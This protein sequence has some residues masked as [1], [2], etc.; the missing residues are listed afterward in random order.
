MIRRLHTGIAALVAITVLA[1]L[2][3]VSVGFD[4]ACGNVE[5]AKA[6]KNV[7]PGGHAPLAIGDSTMLLALPAL[8]REGY[9]V[10]AHG[11]RQI[12]EGLDVMREAKRAN[13]LP[14]LIVI[15]LGADASI[16]PQQLAKAFHVAG[17]KRVLGLVTPIELGGGTSSDADV[18]R[19]AAKRHPKRSVLLDWVAYSAGHSDWFQP[20]DLHLTFS[21]ADG[22]A[23]LLRR[24]LPYARAGALPGRPPKGKSGLGEA[25]I[26]VRDRAGT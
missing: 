3:T 24:A 13:R 22:F 25:T 17:P 18:V 14:H 11:C 9:Q 1:L 5:T 26:P 21:G 7:N 15:A 8:A 19:A 2:P 23:R 12:E 10:N 4:P 6:R 16:S 20:D